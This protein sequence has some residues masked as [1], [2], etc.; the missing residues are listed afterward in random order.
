LL[1][2]Y[3]IPPLQALTPGVAR[4]SSL[5]NLE[6]LTPGI[7]RTSPLQVKQV[8][9]D[10]YLAYVVQLLYWGLGWEMPA[11]IS[12]E[13][14]V[15]EDRASIKPLEISL[16]SE[17][18]IPCDVEWKVR[19]LDNKILLKEK[20]AAA[21]KERQAAIGIDVRGK[22][23]A[24]SYFVDIWARSG[25]K[26][27]GFGS[28]YLE[29]TGKTRIRAVE[30]KAHCK[31]NEPLAGKIIIEAQ[32]DCG[33][34]ELWIKRMDGFGRITG[35][36]KLNVEKAGQG[37]SREILFGMDAVTPLTVIQY[38]CI[39]LKQ[40]G[41][42]VDRKRSSFSISNLYPEN[43][44]RYIQWADAPYSR[45]NMSYL[46]RLY[47]SELAKAG[48]DT[49]LLWSLQSYTE[50][51]YMAN[52]RCLL[53]ATRI[54]D[55][56]AAEIGTMAQ[57]QQKWDS[58]NHVRN[59][60]LAD[61]RYRDKLAADLTRTAQRAASYSTTEFSMG[62][63]C[64]LGARHGMPLEFCFCSNSVAAFRQMLKAEY[65]SIEA[66]NREYTAQYGTFD[67]IQPVTLE[68]AKKNANLRPL[69]VDYRRY[70]ENEWA[71][72]Y[73]FGAETIQKVIPDA[74]VGYEG[75]DGTISSFNGGD[76]DKL[77]RGMK[78]NNSYDG[79]FVP[80][81]VK[82][83]SRPDTLL[84]MGWTGG[85]YHHRSEIFH[86]YIPWKHLLRG[87][88]AHCQWAASPHYPIGG[89]LMAPDL[90]WYD[91]SVF[92]Q[93]EV[94]EIKQGIGKLLINAGKLHD[95]VGVMYSAGSVHVAAMTTGI[96]EMNE[97]LNNVV[98]LL[99]DNR[100]GF[101]I[102]SYRQ[103][104]EGILGAGDFRI[105]ILPF[106]Q[107]LSR[108]EAEAI[109]AFVD[110]GGVVIADLR[111][112]VCDEHGKPYEQGILDDV[113]GIS[114]N[115]GNPKMRTGIMKI[116]TDGCTGDVG[117]VTADASV[118]MA[119]GSANGR[120]DQTPGYIV[121]QYGNGKA[122]LLNFTLTGYTEPAGAADVSL[123]LLKPGHEKLEAALK[124]V[125]RDAGLKTAVTIRPD[126]PGLRVYRYQNGNQE[127]VGLLQ[128]LQ[129]APIEYTKGT[130]R[131]LTATRVNMALSKSYHIYDMRKHEYLGFSDR[132][133]MTV[134]TGKARLLSL[135]PYQVKKVS[136]SAPWWVRG[137]EELKYRVKIKTDGTKAGMHVVHWSLISPGGKEVKWYTGNQVLEQGAG[138]GRITL[139]LN[140]EPG[141]WKLAAR[142]TATGI[143]A[144]RFFVVTKGK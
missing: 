133:D 12:G 125:L 84:G 19:S 78:F 118:K 27:L 52:L 72:I 87:A 26:T 74:R 53:Y 59:P 79:M 140:E 24:G 110:K 45:Q 132:V 1:K 49:I 114:Q 23:P 61:P 124:T 77:M 30:I 127:Y 18:D 123:K 134:E 109:R 60:C 73:R 115:T 58:G 122:V 116:I 97:V 57:L 100:V 40:N 120:M 101:R 41:L 141:I 62:D 5:F 128:E 6:D 70:M 135:M 98:S 3:D 75:S 107:A 68:E 81:A 4:V 50:A 117:R 13:S 48:V 36:T 143:S 15:R 139:A 37:E 136:L 43:D 47:W 55:K 112:G 82:D 42:I 8:E 93:R 11:R 144:T 102:V 69:W 29:L 85:Y 54:V 96:F 56:A 76:Y 103:V 106:V 80:L 88:N 131:K 104:R 67:E 138:E 21:W 89:S 17:K 22:L 25:G 113:F 142:D 16:K 94:A 121:H 51:P 7:A 66:V 92:S 14:F 90:S 2:G 46:D 126:V 137:G 20:T 39:D 10:Y 65:K 108:Q 28:M 38:L 9:Y 44:F 105:L 63:E 111:P 64:W 33:P 35:K 119:G 86:R 95:G 83:F 34:S 31:Q 71:G 91:F 130:A 99:E 129:D 32:E